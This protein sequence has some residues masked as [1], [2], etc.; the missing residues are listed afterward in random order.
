MIYKKGV[1]LSHF[2]ATTAVL[3]FLATGCSTQVVSGD[4]EIIQAVSNHVVRAVIMKSEDLS[5]GYNL[6]LVNQRRAALKWVP[7]SRQYRWVR[8][9]VFLSKE[10][11][12]VFGASF[13]LARVP[14]ELPP[15]KNGDWVEMWVPDL[16]ALNYQSMNVPIVLRRICAVDAPD[17]GKACRENARK[18]YPAGSGPISNQKPDMS[19][20]TFTKRYDLEGKLLKP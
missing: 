12:G 20:L 15:L 16:Y 1:R 4:P 7:E 2:I 10:Y 9:A 13:E 11:H 6:P 3:L 5:E 8:Y 18:E 19:T 14:D 17:N